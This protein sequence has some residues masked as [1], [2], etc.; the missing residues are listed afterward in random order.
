MSDIV[1]PAPQLLP[2]LSA[3]PRPVVTSQ[4]EFNML[5]PE[6]KASLLFSWSE[7]WFRQTPAVAPKSST[8]IVVPIPLTDSETLST[9]GWKQPPTTAERESLRD[10]W[11]KY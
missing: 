4:H 10:D 1:K 3:P 9:E 11:K 5:S 6:A 2:P 7:F 8:S